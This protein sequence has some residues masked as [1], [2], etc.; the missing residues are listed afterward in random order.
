MR[1]EDINDPIEVIAVFRQ[2]KLRPLKFRW[3][4]RVYKIERVNGGWVTDEGK[5]RL[6]HYSVSANSPDVYEI[7]YNS[8]R[9]A[10]NIDRVCLEG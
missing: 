3:R 5:N 4:D 1:F 9:F 6:Y 7:S 2:G 8:D 10:W